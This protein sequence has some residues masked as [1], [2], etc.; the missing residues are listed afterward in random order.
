MQSYKLLITSCAMKSSPITLEWSTRLGNH[1]RPLAVPFL[2]FSFG[3]GH[4]FYNFYFSYL[5]FKWHGGVQDS[6][7]D[8]T[9]SGGIAWTWENPIQVPVGALLALGHGSTAMLLLFVGTV[10]SGWVPASL[11]CA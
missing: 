2:W 9:G 8:W 4:F 10:V 11:F 6:G 5:L 1:L 3:V 7:H